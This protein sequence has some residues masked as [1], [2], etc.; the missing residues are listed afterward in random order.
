MADIV[1]EEKGRPRAN[2]AGRR[3]TDPEVSA[4]S[5]LTNVQNSLFVPNL[6]PFVN[7]NQTYT[8]SPSRPV[9]SEEETT[10]TEEEGE[11]VPK[12]AEERPPL[13]RPLSSVSAALDEGEP[14]FA[15]LPDGT[16]L[17]GWTRTDVEELNDQVRHMLHSRRNKFKRSMKG[18]G[19]YVSKR[20]RL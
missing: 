12:K 8:L 16:S 9:E 15:I 18:F 2:P 17:E 4:L 7:R 11:G 1:R 6:G 5:T 3:R 20:K 13:T 14:R 10:A 19:K